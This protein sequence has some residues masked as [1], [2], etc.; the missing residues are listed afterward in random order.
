MELL[1]HLFLF[2][3]LLAVGFIGVVGITLAGFWLINF[4]P[5]LSPAVVSI[6]TVI[7]I[8]YALSYNSIHNN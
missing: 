1:K 4:L 6:I 5:T 7:T 3:L 2:S 8:V